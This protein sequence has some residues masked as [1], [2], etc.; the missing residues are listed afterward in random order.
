MRKRRRT[1]A[2][3]FVL[4]VGIGCGGKAEPRDEL[5]VPPP[6]PPADAR[7]DAA[8]EPD[9]PFVERVERQGR[10]CVKIRETDSIPVNCPDDLMPD[11][12]P[13][14]LI[15]GHN[16]KCFRVYERK[17]G[18]R[19]SRYHW[20]EGQVRCP[21]GGPNVR[22]PN[23]PFVD[24]KTKPAGWPQDTEHFRLDEESL[25]CRRRVEANPPYSVSA[26]CPEELLPELVG[27]DPERIER[28]C[29]YQGVTV[30]CPKP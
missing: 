18:N 3:P 25:T 8:P 24:I 13:G 19:T 28:A 23:R 20:D 16:D 14:E 30:K 26:P 21:P 7:P 6:P 2:S 27:L 9:A 15:V 17:L 12:L 1:F 10:G 22:L 4:T 5:P 11:A 29:T